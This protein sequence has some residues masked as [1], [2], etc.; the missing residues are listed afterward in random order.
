MLTGREDCARAFFATLERIYR[1]EEAAAIG[2]NT[3]E[4]WRQA[5]QCAPK[6]KGTYSAFF[7]L[8]ARYALNPTSSRRR[9]L[10]F[11]AQAILW[12]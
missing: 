5:V 2:S 4:F 8:S 11:T 9:A 10:S 12:R 7:S 3:Y 1:D 6:P